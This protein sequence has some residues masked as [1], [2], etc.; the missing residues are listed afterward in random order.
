MYRQAAEHLKQWK[1]NPARKPLVIQGA[2]Q[3]GK[4]YLARTFGKEDFETVVEMNFERTPDLASLF[5]GNDPKKTAH[6]IE[7]QTRI[8]VRP[9]STLLFLDEIQAAPPVLTSLRYFH[10]SMPDLHVL[11]AGS[12][13]E[14]ALSELPHQMP[15]GRV[16]YLHMGPMQFEEF[17]PAVGEDRLKDFVGELAPGE[18]VPDAIHKKLLDLFR[19]FVLVGGMPGAVAAYAEAG[20]FGRCEE[21]K[22]SIVSTLKDDFGKYGKRV[23]HRRLV[24]V[25]T[26]LPAMVGEKTKYANIDRNERAAV[27]AEVLDLLCMARLAFR[28]RH[29][30]G[31]GVPMAAEASD[32]VFKVICLDVGLMSTAL[33]LSLLDFE[34]AGDAMLVN[35]GALCEQ[36]VGQHL[37]HSLPLYREPE[38]HYW[39][40]E[41]AN[42]AAEVDY[43]IAE[44]TTVIPVEVKAGKTGT[45]KSLH[46]FLKEK[47]R[48]FGV[49]LC[50]DQP[51]LL[52]ARTSVP[53]APDVPFR[54][55]SLPLYM[56]GQIRRLARAAILSS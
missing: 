44:G 27:L 55:L 46:Q 32:T 22:Q 1:D 28:V 33:G 24:D 54:L 56:T 10:E 21:I 36:A 12:L 26:R 14:F 45:L 49:R 4:S 42:A 34:R 51:S 35:N 38:L 15:V 53:G 50:S 8:P 48:S 16:E 25:F 29:S 18:P 47:K 43:L 7:L 31:N 52:D 17:L 6:L 5:E 23:D 40:R 2:R 11:A 30:A 3:V 20:S 39:T 19:T 41:K 9:G 37:L 13:L